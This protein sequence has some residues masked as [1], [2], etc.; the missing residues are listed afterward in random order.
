[1]PA[2]RRLYRSRYDAARTLDSF[3]NPAT[4]WGHHR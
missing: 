3:A 1:M 4:R 2:G